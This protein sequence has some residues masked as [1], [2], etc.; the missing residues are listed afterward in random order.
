M[1]EPEIDIYKNLKRNS[2]ITKLAIISSLIITLTALFLS[3]DAHKNSQKFIYGIS[4][5]NK[6]LPLEQIEIKE[7]E[8]VFVKGHIEL[9]MTNFYQYDQ[10][11]YTNK[12]EKA[13]WLIDAESGKELYNFYKSNGHFNSIIQT[14]SSQSVTDIKIEVNST[15]EFIIEAVIHLNKASQLDENSYTL[16]CKGIVQ[17]VSRNYPKNPYGYLISNFKE[18]SKIKL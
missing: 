15:G 7:L 14:N 17:K 2:I 13:L 5:D 11:N 12:I 16:V 1:N 4:T 8:T 9:F 3:S 6:L 18:I 10:W